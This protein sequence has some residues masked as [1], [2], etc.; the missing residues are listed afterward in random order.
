MRFFGPS[1]SIASKSIVAFAAL[2]GL[3]S[4]A[5]A[6]NIVSDGGFESAGG[7]NVYSS[8]SIDSGSWTVTQGAVYIDTQDPYVYAGNNSLNLTLANLYVPNTVAQTLS[9]V[10]GTSYVVN[11]WADAD[12]TNTF[13]LTEN[14]LAVY[15]IANSIVQN[16]F[17][18]LTS[19]SNEFVDYI[20][21]FTATSSS[22]V[23]D[24]TATGDPSI[25]SAFGSVMI[26]NVSVTAAPEPASVA[27]MLSGLFCIGLA[28]A[29]RHLRSFGC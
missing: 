2:L 15:G 25:G 28:A 7:G 21:V 5:H 27:L 26:D 19:N 14:G 4:M 24:F 13:S 11:F 8:Q 3:S 17:P 10:A 1:L 16:G 9:T 22:T 6:T 12:S 18:S 20:G 29:A 23:L